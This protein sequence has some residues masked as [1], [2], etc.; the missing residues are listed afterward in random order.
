MKRI[1]LA[2]FLALIIL[3]TAF[4]QAASAQTADYTG[5]W[6]CVGIDAGDGVLAKEYFG[7]AAE[8]LMQLRL[9][10]GGT[11]TLTSAGEA[12][13]G[14]WSATDEGISVL[15]E[16]QHVLFRLEN[17]QLINTEQ[18][19]TSYLEKVPDA[20]KTGGFL[21]LIIGKAYIG[22]WISTSADQGDGV[23]IT[24]IGGMPIKGLITLQINADG[25][26]LVNS[27]GEDEQGQW[28]ETNGG[29]RLV[30]ADESIDL[31]LTNG[32]LTQ[33]EEGMTLYFS[34]EEAFQSEL[35]GPSTPPSP[36][37]F[38][39]AA[40]YQ[41][42]G[43]TFDIKTLFPDGSILTLNPD[44]T[45]EAPLGPDFIEKFTWA[46][47]GDTMSM[48]GA[49]VL[50]SP[51]WD[52]DKQEISFYYGTDAITLVY[53]Q[54]I[55][56]EDLT[57]GQVEVELPVDSAE[58]VIT[59]VT[60]PKPEPEPVTQGPGSAVTML[61]TA[62]FADEGWVENANSRNDR[63]D[64]STVFFELKDDSASTLGS[65]SLTA[66]IEKVSNYR[67]K[68]KLLTER[69]IAQGRDALD[70]TTIGGF[71]FLGTSYERWGWQ[72]TEYTA[73]S[74][75][76]SATLTVLIERPELIGESRLQ[77]VLNSITYHLPEMS[78]PNVDPPLP[79]DGAPY[80]PA[81][82]SLPLGDFELSAAWLR[83][84]RPIIL[85]SIFDNN[86][87]F[88][89]NRLY[90]LTGKPL[91]ALAYKDGQFVTDSLFAEGTM[92]L[93]D[94]F[95]RLSEGKDDILYISHGIF[96]TLALR[97]GA[98]V[99]DYPISGEL[100]MHPSGEWGLTFY[101]NVDPT[102]VSVDP[103]GTLRQE[104]WVLS[105]L[106]NAGTR[107]GRFSMINHIQITED[108]I[109]VAGTDTLTDDAHRIAAFNLKGEEL[110]TFGGK[111]FKDDD[112]LGAV[113]GILESERSILVMDGN[114][115]AFQLFSPQGDYLGKISCDSF[116]GTNYPW[117][118]SMIAFEDGALVSASQARKDGSG[119]ELLLFLITGY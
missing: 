78:P 86:L 73:R 105:G 70:E 104:P 21:S 1:G 83:I 55:A 37:G 4:P 25:S 6:V 108:R 45:G 91:T 14:T 98:I 46:L 115:R 61:F 19:V 28:T 110:F 67:N 33:T 119:N 11:L 114:Y 85:D 96:N 99:G 20:P 17:G 63:K 22:T 111:E 44:G 49:Y 84:D 57:I 60:E 79:E 89:G 48:S 5:N 16:G 13:P 29:I 88:V 30:M 87:R 69:A 94:K 51:V 81:T 58:A 43:S 102:L 15:V 52:A 103:D 26:V 97:D 113:T 75:D 64:Y 12:I 10:A 106:N 56:Q 93:S 8:E 27:M 41:A 100:V 72:Y 53:K 112:S 117:L 42:A 59:A 109:Y 68:I 34:R 80:V 24:D 47:D 23:L 95:K 76:E 36:V 118:S 40:H 9:E 77:S 2:V 116:L 18:G 32:Q 71:H 50:F 90:A 38:W 39:E 62:S 74:A 66:S 101:A 65:V 35:T 3:G 7:Y 54:L 92:T 82:S 31:S 107:Q